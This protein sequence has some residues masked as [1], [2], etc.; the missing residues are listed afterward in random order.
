[1]DPY[2]R[3]DRTVINSLRLMTVIVAI[4][5]GSLIHAIATMPAQHASTTKI[6]KG[7]P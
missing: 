6:Q 1:M 3:H 2:E 7:N 5:A 4:M